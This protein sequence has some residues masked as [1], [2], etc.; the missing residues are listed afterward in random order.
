MLDFVVFD[1]SGVRWRLGQNMISLIRLDMPAFGHCHLLCKR[2]HNIN[3]LP[4]PLLM[5]LSLYSNSATKKHGG[6]SI[7]RLSNRF[8]SNECMIN[9]VDL[10]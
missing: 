7:E 10:F 9:S 6:I 4:T 3:P 5:A 1:P 2:P 8:A